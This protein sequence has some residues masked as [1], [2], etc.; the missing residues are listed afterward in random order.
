MSV[1]EFTIGV[2][3]TVNLGNFES[4]RVEASVTLDSEDADFEH[5]RN[6]AQE[7]LGSL[8]KESFEAQRNPAWFASIV[9]KRTP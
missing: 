2:S 1:K 8:L 5:L 3:H 4:L 9:R 7:S 6:E